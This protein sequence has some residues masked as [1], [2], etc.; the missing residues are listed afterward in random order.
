MI[1]YKITNTINSRIYIGK[2]NLVK[3][4]FEASIYYGSGKLIKRAIAKYG[5]ENFTREILYECSSEEEMNEKE[6]FY[7]EKLGSLVPIGY[8]IQSGGE[9][10]DNGVRT[11]TFTLE[12]IENIKKGKKDYKCS[13]ETKKKLSEAGKN[14]HFPEEVRQKMS[15]AHKGKKVSE[16]TKKK[17]SKARKGR[18]VK[19][20]TKEFLRNLYKGR[21]RGKDMK[22]L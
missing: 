15:K 4:D 13:D 6:K 14:R 16:E 2:R 9:G 18:K 17:I 20:K 22:W 10:G 7:I 11:R 12:W 1:I 19:E 5:I 3:D 21:K 8:N